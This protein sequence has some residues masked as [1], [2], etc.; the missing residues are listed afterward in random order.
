MNLSP[1]SQTTF[2]TMPQVVLGSTSPFRKGLLD[3]LHIPFIQD[4]PQIDET[5]LE[6][7]PPKEMV[8]RLSYEKANVFTN[9]YPQHII[10]TSDQCA[11]FNHQTIGK[12]HTKENAIQQ[13]SQFSNNQIT[14]Y[15][16]L[17]V[18]NTQTGKTYEYLDTTVVHFRT[19]STEIINNYLEIEQPFNCAG[20][21]K[22]EG[23]GITLFKQ[24]DSQDP[25]ALIGLPLIAL[26]DIFYEMGF[27]LPLK[28]A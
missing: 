17:V 6:N 3:K 27:A 12:P 19:L 13:L 10:I 2:H 9:K 8:L 21:F 14:F 1:S 26:T 15:T 18:T 7:E 11:V 16:G 20:S 5:P 24:I 23:L 25:N 28:K 4:A 22:S